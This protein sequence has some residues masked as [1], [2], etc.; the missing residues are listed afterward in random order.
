MKAPRGKKFIING[1]IVSVPADNTITVSMLTRLRD[2]TG[3]I[4]VNL[5]RRFQHKR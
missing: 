1:N 4:N 3:I 5:K 2:E